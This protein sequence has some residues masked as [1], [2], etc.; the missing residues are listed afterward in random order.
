MFGIMTQC[1]DFLTCC[2]PHKGGL[3]LFKHR[4]Y[5]S[6]GSE[7]SYIER[8]HIA[9]SQHRD[10]AVQINRLSVPTSDQQPL[11]LAPD[12]V[13]TVTANPWAFRTF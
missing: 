7:C 8:V 12:Y 3:S 1:T 6:L 10:Q 2:H 5:A 4:T 13:A 9:C 11:G